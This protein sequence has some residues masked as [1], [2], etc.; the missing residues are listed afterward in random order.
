MGV[1]SFGRGS[2][3]V[4]LDI[5]SNSIHVAQLK[6]GGSQFFLTRYGSIRIP[7]GAVVEGEIVDT[8]AV[9]HSISQLWRKAGISE[10]SI[11]TG[12]ANQ[13]V[14]VRMV[15]FP[16]MEKSELE[17]ALRFQAQDYIPIPIEEAILDFEVLGEYTNVNEER[18][19]EVL[20]VAAQRDMINNHLA[21]IERAGLK[22]R[23]IDASAFAI[24]RS[25]IREEESVLPPET[26]GE[27]PEATGII[28][29]SAG[30]TIIVVVEKGQP[31][32]TRVSSLAG[33]DFTQSVA[34]ALNLTFDEAEDLKLAAGLPP[35]GAEERLPAGFPMERQEMGDAAQEI[36]ERQVS[37]FIAEI[38]RSLDYY[39]T[40]ATQVR[41]IRK[42]ILSG[43]GANLRNLESYLEKGLQAEVEMGKPLSAVKLQTNI[44][45]D[46][47][48]ADELAM[49]VCLGLAMRGTQQ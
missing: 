16:W 17:G 9:G 35:L 36:L 24:V 33:N 49:P 13:K 43:G 20:L 42:L 38:R 40:Q 37:K 3:P 19:V 46:E 39:L 14:V 41:A 30:L 47:I 7:M 48:A 23:I 45:A 28:H 11:V 26:E 6:G 8:E 29:V 12:V 25:L 27:V 31:R 22:P 15:E 5:G 4:G 21:A 44:S 1:F 34:D 2:S 18:M 32:F 10:K